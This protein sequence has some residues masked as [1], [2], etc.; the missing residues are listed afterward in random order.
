MNI[1]PRIIAEAYMQTQDNDLHDYKIFC[2]GGKAEGILVVSNRAA[3]MTKNFYDIHQNGQKDPFAYFLNGAAPLSSEQLSLM[4]QLAERLS[5][6]FPHVRVD[7]YILNDGSV[8]FGEMTF[9]PVSGLRDWDTPE[10][11]RT[12]GGL[13][14]LPE[15]KSPIPVREP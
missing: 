5:E 8:K 10:Q 12:Y 3:E 15:H 1:Q 11:D 13:L 6:G 9:S 4:I 7:F 2:F 14:H